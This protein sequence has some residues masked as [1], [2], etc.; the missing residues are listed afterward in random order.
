MATATATGTAA[1][2][3]TATGMGETRLFLV[4]ATG[5]DG[6]NMDLV[7]E[8]RTPDEAIAL[9]AADEVP[10]TMEGDPMSAGPRAI[11][12]P[13]PTGAPGVVPWPDA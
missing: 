5:G 13:A 7:V 11:P 4:V 10:S 3:A 2:G 6:E 8:A 1:V 9:W 12:L